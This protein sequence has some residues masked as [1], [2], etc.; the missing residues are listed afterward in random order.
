MV[1]ATGVDDFDNF[2][3]SSE[4]WRIDDQVTQDT[5]VHDIA[6]I[7]PACRMLFKVSANIVSPSSIWFEIM[8]FGSIQR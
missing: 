3:L 2:A 4:G 8:M 7:V 5:R 1:I 6:V